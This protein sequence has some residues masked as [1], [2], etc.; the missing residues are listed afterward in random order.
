MFTIKKEHFKQILELS[1][2][3]QNTGTPLTDT[4]NQILQ[5]T[6]LKGIL[7]KDKLISMILIHENDNN[8]GHIYNLATYNQYLRQGLSSQLLT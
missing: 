6:Y 4:F 2:N 7:E 1:K 5:C 3:E 8:E